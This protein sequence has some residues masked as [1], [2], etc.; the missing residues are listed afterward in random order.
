MSPSQGADATGRLRALVARLEQIAATP[1]GTDSTDASDQ[2]DQVLDA[3]SA[4]TARSTDR[5][6]LRSILAGHPDPQVREWLRSLV[7]PGVHLGVTD[8]ERVYAQPAVPVSPARVPFR[9]AVTLLTKPFPSGSVLER[10]RFRKKPWTGGYGWHGG[11]PQS[12]SALM[13][14]PINGAGVPLSFLLQ[15][16]LE[17]VESNVYE[18]DYA[19]V[20]LPTRGVLQLF[21][22]TSALLAA[23]TDSATSEPVTDALAAATE[24]RG[25]G[26]VR[27]PRFV[28]HQVVCVP[29]E[30]LSD[31]LHR[32]PRE[33]AESDLELVNADTAL[34]LPP[35]SDVVDLFE[36]GERDEYA[37]LE[38]VLDEDPYLRNVAGGLELAE[39][40][41][42]EDDYVDLAPAARMGGYPVPTRDVWE[43]VEKRVRCRR[44]GEVLVLFDLP[45]PRHEYVTVP[46][47]R[48]LVAAAS[49]EVATGDF[50]GTVACFYPHSGRGSAM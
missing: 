37:V 5:A 2:A 3:L 38:R 41:P 25:V 23:T 27:K 6:L 29:P 8:P 39:T 30:E 19:T 35:L 49:A 46:G 21:V 47:W 11:A 18:E 4:S 17:G 20:G 31:E 36:E 15:V 22:D 32:T 24:S 34:T 10:R 12:S 1:G 50:S 44:G 26:S 7:V 28:D 45:V 40:S 33:S 42:V 13:S 9:P 43:Q 16:D 14:W 48:L